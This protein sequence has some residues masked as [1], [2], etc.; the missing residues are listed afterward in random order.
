MCVY[1]TDAVVH[2]KQDPPFPPT[3]PVLSLPF[4]LPPLPLS[5][6]LSLLSIC[7]LSLSFSLSLPPLY[8]LSLSFSLSLTDA[9]FHGQHD[10]PSPPGAHISDREHCSCE[11]VCVKERERELEGERQGGR[12]IEIVCESVRDCG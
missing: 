11:G 9:V 3:A 12:E 6:S 4:F 7:S 1:L 10:P 8:L 5:L 2:S